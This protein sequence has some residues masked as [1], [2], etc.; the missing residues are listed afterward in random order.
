M[1]TAKHGT[2]Y[3]ASPLTRDEIEN[4][5]NGSLGMTK[6]NVAIDLDDILEGLEVL[7]DVASEAVTGTIC[8]QEIGYRMV[9]VTDYN[10]VVFEITGWVDEDDLN[11][12][13]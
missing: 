4:M 3:I 5:Q 2:E 10:E 1:A 7:N 9:D 8:L 12:R 6:A 13:F 11:D